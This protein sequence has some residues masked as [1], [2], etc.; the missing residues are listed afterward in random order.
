MKLFKKLFFL[1]ATFLIYFKSYSQ[2]FPKEP[3]QTDS[4]YSKL[5]VR[6]IKEHNNMFLTGYNIDVLKITSLDEN[7]HPLKSKMLV[8]A[9]N[10]SPVSKIGDYIYEGKRCKRF[11]EIKD[12]ILKSYVLYTYDEISGKLIKSVEFDSN[13]EKTEEITYSYNPISSQTDRFRKGKLIERSIKTYDKDFFLQEVKNTSYKDGSESSSNLVTSKYKIKKDGKQITEIRTEDKF[14]TNDELIFDENK[15]LLENS[16]LKGKMSFKYEYLFEKDVKSKFL[17]KKFINEEGKPTDSINAYSTFFY[18][19]SNAAF[20]DGYIV[21]KDKAGKTISEIEYLDMD[22]LIKDG[23]FKIFHLNGK[24]K[25]EAKYND[26]K[27]DG[28]L[29]MFYEDGTLK[30]VE[31][32]EFGKFISGKCFDNSG[33]EIEFKPY[34]IRP[35]YIGTIKIGEEIKNK[36]VYPV[37]Q[38]LLKREESRMLVSFTIDKEGKMTDIKVL[39]GKS[40]KMNQELIR[41]LQT[42]PQ[43]KPG[44]IDG[45]L[46]TFKFQQYFSL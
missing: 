23:K 28:E 46:S 24:I 45:E 4:L 12:G 35:E 26:D 20:N 2:L 38:K 5:K 40:E 36:F 8:K 41:V 43:W 34:E 14:V 6:V 9:G 42:L 16:I 33:K 17:F 15:L 7:G 27:L 21:C 30:R 39:E 18:Y 3:Y 1:F 25:K 37:D 29:K 22:Y 31:N 11:N 44:Y 10:R 19:T 32:Y 13:S